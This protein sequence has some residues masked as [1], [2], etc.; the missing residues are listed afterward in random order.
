MTITPWVERPLCLI[1]SAGTL[2]TVP[3]VVMSITWSPWL[4][5]SAPASWPRRLGELDGLDAEPS[6]ALTG[7]LAG[8]ASACRSRSRSRRA[9]R[10]RSTR[11]VPQ[12]VIT[13]SPFRSRIPVTPEWPGHR[14]AR[15]ARLKR[16]RWPFARTNEK[17]V[18]ARGVQDADQLVAVAELIAMIPS[19]LSG[20]YCLERSAYSSR[21][22]LGHRREVLRILEVRVAMTARIVSV[23][24]NGKRLT[25][26]LPL[27]L[28]DPSGSSVH[29][30]R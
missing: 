30:S 1:P 10:G 3:P 4:T 7:L 8:C 9:G 13:S 18:L 24:W 20:V 16:N 17:V 26:A 29:L 27:R 21:A 6:P 19:A 23:C 12:L 28:R 14:P 11:D 5:T 2:I 25:I 22:P 15:A